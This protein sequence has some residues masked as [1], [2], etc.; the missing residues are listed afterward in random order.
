MSA[1]SG[2]K[3]QYL[4]ESRGRPKYLV[5]ECRLRERQ[6]HRA[7]HGLLGRRAE[8]AVTHL[9]DPTQDHLELTREQ[10]VVVQIPG[11]NLILSR[12]R[13]LLR[14]SSADKR[15][16]TAQATTTRTPI[17]TVTNTNPHNG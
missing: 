16:A 14:E 11:S 3:L 6:Q 8:R 10:P 17:P 7:H 4:Q 13:A 1:S 15:S 5:L 2:A 9:F 12:W